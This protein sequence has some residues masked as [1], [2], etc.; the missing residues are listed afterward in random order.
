MYQKMLKP[1][2]FGTVFLFSGSIN[3]SAYADDA[4]DAVIVKERQANM[5]TIGKNM[6]V[7]GTFVKEGSGTVADVKTAAENIASLAPKLTKWF[8]EGSS[9]EDILDPP[10]GAKVEIWNEWDK[11]KMIAMGMEGLALGVAQAVESNDRNVVG[12]ALG[13]LGKNACAA[14][15]KPY[16]EKLD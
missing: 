2:I 7:L 4:Q 13:A 16:R 9:M 11:F 6:K 14:C 10:T 8:P 12:A 15:H 5:K 1:I 3:I